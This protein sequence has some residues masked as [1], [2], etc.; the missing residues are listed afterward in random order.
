MGKSFL[1]TQV[2]DPK[3]MGELSASFLTRSIGGKSYNLSTDSDSI[4][5]ELSLLKAGISTNSDVTLEESAEMSLGTISAA[6]STESKTYSLVT[7]CGDTETID[8]ENI[9]DLSSYE[10]TVATSVS[11]TDKFNASSSFYSLDDDI[12]DSYARRYASAS[13]G[14]TADVVS[15][16]AALLKASNGTSTATGSTT[17]T[18]Y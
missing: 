7:T 2:Q 5:I 15:F 14:S 9:V 10:N 12:P 13:A 16:T 4:S 11:A 3:T 1:R 6:V 18:T 8:N 17:T